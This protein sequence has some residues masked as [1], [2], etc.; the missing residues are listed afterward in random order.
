MISVAVKKQVSKVVEFNLFG[1]NFSYELAYN[2]KSKSIPLKDLVPVVSRQI[3]EAQ[4]EWGRV[5]G[6]S[7]ILFYEKSDIYG[8]MTYKFS[9]EADLALADMMAKKD[10][11]QKIHQMI[12]YMYENRDKLNF[13]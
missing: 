11:G 5:D 13:I 3:I 9:V 8:H 4:Y 7:V 10:E 6:K 12:S 2:D 1:K